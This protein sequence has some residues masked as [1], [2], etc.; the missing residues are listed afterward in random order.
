MAL[1]KMRV[2]F[3]ID[4]PVFLSMLATANSGMKI[5]VY[6][7]DKPPKELKRQ[8]N[9]HH[10]PKLLAAP[11]Q[12]RGKGGTTSYAAILAHLVAHKDSGFKAKELTP[13]IVAIGKAPNSVSPQL[14]KLR[15]DGMV[16]KDKDGLYRAT[17]KGIAHHEKQAQQSQQAEA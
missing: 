11:K 17:P 6:G 4:I 8:L 1:K 15:V 7:D 5:D 3:D 2:S 9:G 13:I 12:R 10:A 16:K 14:G